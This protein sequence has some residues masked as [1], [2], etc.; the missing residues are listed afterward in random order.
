MPIESESQV[1]S[2]GSTSTVNVTVRETPLGPGG[3][4]RHADVILRLD[5]RRVA[6]LRNPSPK[7]HQYDQ[8]KMMVWWKDVPFSKRDPA[9]LRFTVKHRSGAKHPGRCRLHVIFT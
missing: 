2:S 9:K 1:N 3:N 4:L 5:A 7:P 8:K 6:H